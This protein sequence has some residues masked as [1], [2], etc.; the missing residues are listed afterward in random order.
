V[1][2]NFIFVTAAITQLIQQKQ[3]PPSFCFENNRP[4]P[5][6][7]LLRESVSKALVFL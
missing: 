5:S 2:Q 3:T 7:A 4:R 1:L 6:L